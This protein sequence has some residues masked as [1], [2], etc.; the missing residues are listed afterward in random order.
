MMTPA[1]IAHTAFL[2][3]KFGMQK[4][5]LRRRQAMAEG[6]RLVKCTIMLFIVASEE[7][8]LQETAV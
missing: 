3:L 4:T 6:R 1:V 2:L 5:A 7:C 8:Q